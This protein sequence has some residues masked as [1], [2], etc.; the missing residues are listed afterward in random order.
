MS[1][2]SKCH[3]CLCIH[4][5]YKTPCPNFEYRLHIP[6]PIKS[7]DMFVEHYNEKSEEPVEGGV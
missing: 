4:C 7:C 2:K 5:A 1:N 3:R 6:C